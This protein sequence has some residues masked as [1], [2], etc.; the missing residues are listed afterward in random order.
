LA[1]LMKSLGADDALN[2]DG[3]GSTTMVAQMPGDDAPSVRNAPS[4]GVQR[5][6]PNGLGFVTA[7]P[8]SVCLR[9]NYDFP[10]YP[11]LV[12]GN[13]G[14]VVVTAQC[15]LESVGFDTGA[16]DPTGTM[17]TATSAATRSFQ[18]AIGLPVVGRVNAATWTALLS[19]GDTPLLRI[20]SKGWAVERV[21]RALTAALHR[22]VVIDG[23]FG[24]QT[25]QAVRD[26]QSSR[27]LIPSGIVRLGTWS[28]LQ[29]GE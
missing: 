6:V 5:P 25:E 28:A 19:A 17:D 10:A 11:K 20:G 1:N 14:D 12:K 7:A 9:S 26:Y 21:Q 15:L 4:D 29:S 2:L 13:T 27:G 22:T 23:D 8:R 18:A 16:G 3:G 24:A